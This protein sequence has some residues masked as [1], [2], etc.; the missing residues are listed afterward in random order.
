MDKDILEKLP[1][2]PDGP[3]SPPQE[4]EKKPLTRDEFEEQ[5]NVFGKHLAALQGNI[6]YNMTVLQ[7]Q[8]QWEELQY[9]KGMLRGLAISQE[10]L[11]LILRDSEPKGRY[12]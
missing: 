10:A 8:N 4:E 11:I 2:C 5:V 1:P 3:C 6:E 7:Q 9:Y 12:R